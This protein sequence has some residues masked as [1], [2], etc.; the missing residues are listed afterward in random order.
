M[1]CPETA[2]IV[3]AGVERK[4]IGSPTD[5]RLEWVAVHRVS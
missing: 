3:P 4:I 5:D 2:R 1:W